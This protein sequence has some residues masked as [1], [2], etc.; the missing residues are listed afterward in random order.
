[1]AGKISKKSW[2]QLLQR[3][4]TPNGRKEVLDLLCQEYVEE[5]RSSIQFRGDAERISYPQFRDKLLQIAG[6]EE[7]HAEWL[8]ARIIVLG[9]EVPRVSF[10]PQQG[11][12]S[13]E[14][15]RLDGVRERRCIWDLEEQL[16]TVEQVDSETAELLRHIVEEEK[17]HREEIVE[18]MMRSDPQG[19][20]PIGLSPIANE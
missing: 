8:K 18:M 14:R 15:L 19:G 16:L 13:W 7:K 4:L 2:G 11:L 20:L 6:Q 3:L 5:I 10:T 17:K 12:N 1:M 9:G